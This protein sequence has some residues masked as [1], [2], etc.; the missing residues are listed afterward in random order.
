MPAYHQSQLFSKA[1]FAQ[2]KYDEFL[3]VSADHAFFWKVISKDGRFSIFPGVISIFKDGGLSSTSRLQSITD[4][5][6]S[7]VYYQSHLN[8]YVILIAIIRRILAHVFRGM[9]FR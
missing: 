6:Y 2:L 8:N 5:L 7:L 9:K 3:H 4:I 1:C